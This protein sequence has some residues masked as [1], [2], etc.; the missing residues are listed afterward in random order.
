[1]VNVMSTLQ[2]LSH[3]FVDRLYIHQTAGLHLGKDIRVVRVAQQLPGRQ[4]AP[5]MPRGQK[6][7]LHTLAR[8]RWPEEDDHASPFSYLCSR[9]CLTAAAIRPPSAEAPTF[10]R[11][12]PI[13]WPIC[14]ASPS[15]LAVS[16]TTLASSSSAS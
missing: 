5:A 16:S 2:R 4:P 6:L 14:A 1:M 11:T 10:W 7:A 12:A 9:C 3:Q 15:S 13:I 8:S